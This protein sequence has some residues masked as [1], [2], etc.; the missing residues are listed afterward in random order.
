[1]GQEK[2]LIIQSELINTIALLFQLSQRL[3][4]IQYRHLDIV[5][6]G[7]INWDNYSNATNV[8]LEDIEC[9]TC[10][11][12]WHFLFRFSPCT[13]Y[14]FSP[15]HLFIFSQTDQMAIRSYNKEHP[16]KLRFDTFRDIIEINFAAQP[17]QSDPIRVDIV[18]GYPRDN[19]ADFDPLPDKKNER[20]L[21]KAWNSLANSYRIPD[22]PDVG[23][24][25][26]RRGWGR[27]GG[28]G[29]DAD[30]KSLRA[31]SLSRSLSASLPR[32]RR[33]RTR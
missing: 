4:M 15:K 26:S 11:S 25:E 13:V 24:V 8:T 30:W 2:D 32:E 1:M 5:F 16:P 23:V 20:D 27:K 17:Q 12:Q 33:V 28:R 29:R 22:I 6:K 19:F 18:R 9:H 31:L 10:H 7:G 21:W 3:K 14:L